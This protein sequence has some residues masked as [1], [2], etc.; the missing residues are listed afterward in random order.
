VST[1]DNA[2]DA[3]IGDF[4]FLRVLQVK[5]R[6]DERTRTADLI[7]LGV[8]GLWLLSV[9]RAFKTRIDRGFSVPSIAHVCRV[10]RPG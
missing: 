1:A 9:A 8:C 5:K 7:S 3:N 4:L 6:A 2:P 10:L